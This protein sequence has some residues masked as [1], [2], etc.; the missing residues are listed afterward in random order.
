VRGEDRGGEI[1]REGTGEGGGDQGE[2]PGRVGGERIT[3][4]RGEDLGGQGKRDLGEQGRG[5]GRAG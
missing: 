2:W 3:T 4:A 5:A 1:A